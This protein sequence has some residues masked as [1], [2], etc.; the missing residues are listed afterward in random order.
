MYAIPSAALVGL[1]GIFPLLVIP[2]EA[3]PKLK[4]QAT[5]RK[6]N[7]LLCFAVGGLIGDVFL[8]LLPEA[9]AHQ[10]N[11]PHYHTKIGLWAIFG[12]VFFMLC[13]KIF[14]EGEDE[15]NDDEEAEAKTS[16]YLNLLANVVDNF[17]HGLAVAGGYALGVNVGICTTAAILLHEVPHEVGDFAILLKSGFTRWQA[18]VAQMITATGGLFG[19]VFGI[20]AEDASNSTVWILPFTSGG[21]IYV[22]LVTIVPDLQKET[23]PIESVKQVL[24]LLFGVAVMAGVT[25]LFGH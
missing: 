14:P 20:I 5:S 19:V 25:I 8:H 9:W 15:A 24:A 18:A 22:S 11:D 23:D 3:V 16:G 17:T 1:S 2:L 21:F 7:I 12:I 10:N 6:F 13:E 4:D